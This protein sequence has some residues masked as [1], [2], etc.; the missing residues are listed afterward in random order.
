MAE[1]SSA[2]Q[3]PD[4]L[5][6]LDLSGMWQQALRPRCTDWTPP[7]P[8]ELAGQIPQCDLTGLLGRG[9]MGAVYRARQTALDREVAVKLL[10]PEA[11]PDGAMAERFRREGRLLA[12]LSHPHIVTSTS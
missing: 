6:G 5:T 7:A 9:G 2:P 10:P 4:D 3:K 12:R 8:E 11:D 1:H